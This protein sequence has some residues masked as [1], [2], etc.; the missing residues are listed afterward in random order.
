M[1]ERGPLA[2]KSIGLKI[3]DDLGHYWEIIQGVVK[4]PQAERKAAQN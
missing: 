1:P 3:S 4:V 2:H